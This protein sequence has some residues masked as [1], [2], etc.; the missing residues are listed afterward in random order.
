M[1]RLRFTV[2]YIVPALLWLSP[3][4]LRLLVESEA[5]LWCVPLHI[6]GGCW[7]LVASRG[8]PRMRI[9]RLIVPAP[10]MLFAL[11]SLRYWRDDIS[12]TIGLTVGGTCAFILWIAYFL[13]GAGRA[14]FAADGKQ[15]RD[16]SSDA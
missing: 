12:L 7:F 5:Y 10:A 3:L 2:R 13:T 16:R 1:N 6:I 15:V 4:W 9:P 14:L 11:D 8:R